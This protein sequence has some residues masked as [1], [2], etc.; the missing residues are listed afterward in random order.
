MLIAIHVNYTFPGKIDLQEFKSVNVSEVKEY[1]EERLQDT[2]R[3]RNATS[4]T[5]WLWHDE[6]ELL[7]YEED[8]LQGFH[9]RWVSRMSR[10]GARSLLEMPLLSIWEMLE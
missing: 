9:E 4:E 5:A 6:D 3:R 1:F 10:P 7:R 8:V 2:E